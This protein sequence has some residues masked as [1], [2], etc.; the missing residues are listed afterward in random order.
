MQ[1]YELGKCICRY[2]K[3]KMSQCVLHTWWPWHLA[4]CSL[5]CKQRWPWKGRGLLLERKYTIV[6]SENNLQKKVFSTLVRKMAFSVKPAKPPWACLSPCC[7]SQCWGR[8]LL[9]LLL[10]S[11]NGHSSWH[12]YR[13]PA[14]SRSQIWVRTRSP[15]LQSS[16]RTRVQS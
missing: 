4:Q 7:L 14:S 13:Y 2:T 3:P 9:P 15:P 8:P 5:F 16:T 11:L 6:C 1:V 10:G 12:E